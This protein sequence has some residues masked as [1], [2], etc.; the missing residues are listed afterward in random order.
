MKNKARLQECKLSE[1]ECNNCEQLK[2]LRTMTNIQHSAHALS[3][4]TLQRLYTKELTTKF[5]GN[6]TTIIIKT[7][8]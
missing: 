6:N 1:A 5:N 3:Y 8:Q 2:T 4:I 7:G